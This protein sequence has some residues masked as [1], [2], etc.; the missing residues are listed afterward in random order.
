M[1]KPKPVIGNFARPP[2]YSRLRMADGGDLSQGPLSGQFWSAIGNGLVNHVAAPIADDVVQGHAALNEH[3]PL[4]YQAVQLHPLAGIPA[5]ALDYR[6]AAQR[7]DTMGM[8][9]ASLSAIPVVENA[10]RLGGTTARTLRDALVSNPASAR[11]AGSALFGGMHKAAAAVNTDQM[12][13][14]GEDE[15]VARGWAPPKKKGDK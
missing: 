15:A 2:A 1:A 9:R 13:S 10:Y 12:Y 5:A 8:I 14:A 3:Y 6:D 7:G 11:T 4:A